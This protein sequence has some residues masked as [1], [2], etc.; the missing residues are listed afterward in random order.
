MM[1]IL[2]LSSAS[3]ITSSPKVTSYLPSSTS[4]MKYARVVPEPS[5]WL[6]GF[7]KT[8]SVPIVEEV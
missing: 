3:P 4:L 7:S 5:A 2:S 1:T 6:V 8:L